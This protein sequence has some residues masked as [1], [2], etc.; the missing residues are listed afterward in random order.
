MPNP[1]P[2][3]APPQ[4]QNVPPAQ[5]S[6]SRPPEFPILIWML[7][8]NRE[9]T[10]EEYE[11]CYAFLREFLPHVPLGA[12]N[13]EDP[14]SFRYC[15]TQLLPVLMM[16]HRRIPRSKW[17]DNITQNGKHWIEQMQDGMPPEKFLWSMIGYHIECGPSLCGIAMTQGT[18]KRVINIGLGIKQVAVEPRGV[19]VLAFIESIRHKLTASEFD[20]LVP[21]VDGEQTALKRAFILLALKESYIHAV[22][23]PLGFDYSRLEF[24][25]PEN[26]VWGDNFPLQG[27]EFRIWT[28]DIGV[29]RGENLVEEKYICACA[30][31]RGSKE[32]VFLWED[33]KRKLE[34]WV[35]FVDIDQM[36]KVIPKLA[37]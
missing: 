33:Q 30:F 13:P 21:M 31:F 1:V 28:V 16:R 14:N 18:Q 8:L 26:K 29:A 27:W 2:N 36:I 12:H 11:A 22:G 6:V 37:A 17:R 23:Q 5:Q 19:P 7:S 25:V 24:N 10:V 34:S 35:Q 9:Y 4:L 32:S 3:Q 20:K 15:V